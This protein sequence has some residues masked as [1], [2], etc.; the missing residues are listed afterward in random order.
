MRRTSGTGGLHRRSDGM[1]IGSVTLPSPDGR[2]RRK[3]VSSRDRNEAIRKLRDLQ[4]DV[5][6][7][8]VTYGPS[9]T[10][11]QWLES[12][13]TSVVRPTARPRTFAYYEQ[14]ARLYVIPR[15]GHIRLDRLTPADV[16]AMIGDVQRDSTR[17]AQKAHQCL[18]RALVVAAPPRAPLVLVSA[19]PPSLRF[20]VRHDLVVVPPGP[21]ALRDYRAADGMTYLAFPPAREREVARGAQTP[22]EILA[23]TPTLVLARVRVE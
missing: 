16:R 8:R 4:R 23:R 2:Q 20:Y 10:V 15:V 9:M 3:T 19:P 5:V 11:A 6:K 21:D 1:W 18:S 22:L 12:W 17:S 7:G 13:L 14:A